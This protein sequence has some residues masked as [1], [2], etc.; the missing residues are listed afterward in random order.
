MYKKWAEDANFKTSYYSINTY[1]GNS[2]FGWKYYQYPFEKSFFT[3][4]SIE[5]QLGFTVEDKKAKTCQLSENEYS[6]FRINFTDAYHNYY[7]VDLAIG[8]PYTVA[9]FIFEQESFGRIYKT[10]D[11]F[12]DVLA[13]MRTA[14]AKETLLSF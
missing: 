1:R 7:S 13:E 10:N 12:S 11:F 5:F 3:V 4:D 6:W 14:S 8:D 9:E 2:P